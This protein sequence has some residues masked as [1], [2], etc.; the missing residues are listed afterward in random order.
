VKQISMVHNRAKRIC[1]R[2][3]FLLCVRSLCAAEHVGWAHVVGWQHELN[4]T[5]GW[6]CVNWA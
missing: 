5:L 6:R 2:M 4:T 1:S 3:P